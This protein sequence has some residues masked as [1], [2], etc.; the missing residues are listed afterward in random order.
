MRERHHVAASYACAFSHENHVAASYA[1]AF[2][3]ENHVARCEHA[4]TRA[5]YI[6]RAAGPADVRYHSPADVCCRSPD[7]VLLSP[8]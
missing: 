1:C 3:H 7:D 6:F 4:T 8:E 2:S 5:D